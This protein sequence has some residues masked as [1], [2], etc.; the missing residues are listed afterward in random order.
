MLRPPRPLAPEKL[1]YSSE[2]SSSEYSTLMQRLPKRSPFAEPVVLGLLAEAPAH[3]YALFTRIC[4]D[5]AGV[6]RWA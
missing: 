1:R 2:Y 4:E 3:G 6:C 5:L